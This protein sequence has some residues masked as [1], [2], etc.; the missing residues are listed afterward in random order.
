MTLPNYTQAILKKCSIDNIDIS[1]HV[2]QL[3]VSTSIF[4]P[5]IT[6]KL[7]IVDVSSLQD[8]L[9]EP[10]KPVSIVY[11]AG[12]SSI[13]R[14][15]NLFTVGS[16][17]GSKEVNNLAGKTEI[18]AIS[19]C[20]FDMQN[21]HSS[22]HQNVPTSEV[23]RKL[24]NELVPGSNIDITKT[25]GL[26]ADIEPFH[27]RGIRLGRAINLVR[28][29]M[30]D[31]K[32]KSASYVYYADQNADY[33]CVPIEQL[34]DKSS[35]P[36][37]TQ[38]VA[39]ISFL[40]EQDTLAYNIISMKRGSTKSGYGSDD[41]SAYQ[42]T[43]RQRGG[44]TNEG[45]DWASGSYTA[46]SAKS[47]KL[48]SVKTKG[49][50]GDEILTTQGADSAGT[51]NHNFMIDS[52]QKSSADF[53]SDVANKNIISSLLLQGSTLVNIPLEGGLE[54]YVG[55][56]CYLD[57][58]SDIGSGDRVKSLYGGQHLVIAQGEYIFQDQNGTMG[59]AAL[60][61]SSGGKQ[62]SLD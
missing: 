28:N 25:K 57:I 5:Y 45:W 52:N 58:P 23:F 31:E 48:S 54:S 61:T 14:E 40:Q 8:A 19:R 53:E 33:H 35:G 59:V 13:I 20:Y 62:G 44:S 17:G 55:K 18:I 39:G 2:R 1:L 42:S 11:T 50:P 47:Y 3:Y 7:S 41:A 30:T 6:A 37:Y 22:Y 34:F 46:P 43:Q 56:G 24:H 36:R 21:E 16:M 15:Y 26:I 9:Y 27:L 4:T 51:V 12:D 29:R 32:Y 60:Q 49:S 10:G 38:K